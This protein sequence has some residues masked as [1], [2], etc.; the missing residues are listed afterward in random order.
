[1]EWIAKLKKPILLKMTMTAGMQI[2]PGSV[3]ASDQLE[4]R[5]EP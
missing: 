5:E 4:D 3:R 1:M 2:L